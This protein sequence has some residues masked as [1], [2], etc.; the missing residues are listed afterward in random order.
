M[1]KAL[2]FLIIVFI[3]GCQGYYKT[4]L[5]T[6]ENCEAAFPSVPCPPPV[7][8]DE[9]FKIDS[10][11]KVTGLQRSTIIDLQNKYDTLTTVFSD[12]LVTIK[13]KLDTVSNKVQIQT[14]YKDRF[15]PIETANIKKLITQIA[16]EKNRGDSLYKEVY[17]WKQ[18]HNKLKAKEESKFKFNYLYLGLVFLF[19][20]III[21]RLLKII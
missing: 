5:I 6:K 13:F 19:V 1:K 7:I 10:L 21:F 18:E 3:G 14:L 8:I 4:K 15:V 9:S 16:I 17:Y 20:L 2:I 12:S 11:V